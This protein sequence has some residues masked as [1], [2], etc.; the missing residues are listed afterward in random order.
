MSTITSG[1]PVRHREAL[2]TATETEVDLPVPQT[3]VPEMATPAGVS[4]ILD[5]SVNTPTAER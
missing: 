1:R 4:F 2:T 3:Q 5:R